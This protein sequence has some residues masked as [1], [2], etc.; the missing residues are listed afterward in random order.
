MAGSNGDY[1]TYLEN[2]WL[3]TLGGKVAWSKVLHDGVYE[4]GSPVSAAT[5]VVNIA[6][7]AASVAKNYKATSDKMEL[8]VYEKVIMGS[9]S[10][11]NNPLDSRMS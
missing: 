1:A 4:I 10:Q 8:A 6:E 9:G 3:G 2:S 11:A 5:P 7:A